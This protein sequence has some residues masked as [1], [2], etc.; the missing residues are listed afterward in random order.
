MDVELHV[1]YNRARLAKLESMFVEDPRY[2]NASLYVKEHFNLRRICQNCGNRSV[3]KR[4]AIPSL[5]IEGDSWVIPVA[6]LDDGKIVMPLQDAIPDQSNFFRPDVLE[7]LRSIGI[8]YR[9]DG[10]YEYVIPIESTADD[11]YRSLRTKTTGRRS[12]TNRRYRYY[13]SVKRDFNCRVLSDAAPEDVVAWDTE[14]E[15]DYESYWRARSD[16][17]RCGYN[18]ESEY[19]QFLAENG[20]LLLARISDAD[21]STVALGYCVPHVYALYFR[22]LKRRIGP[23]YAKYALGS[24]LNFMFLDYIYEREL[25]TPLNLGSFAHSYKEALL[26]IVVTKPELMFEDESAHQAVFDS[27]GI[28][29]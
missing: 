24:A 3:E 18:V 12:R 27:V 6:V 7:G 10:P 17:R 13:R 2:G 20:Q 8:L 4:L 1:T 29:R 25:L 21:D 23:A 5:I 19:F 14:L 16:D 28:A 9:G 15:Y 11:Y 26:P 22:L